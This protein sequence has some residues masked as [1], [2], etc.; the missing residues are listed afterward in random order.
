VKKEIAIRIF[1]LGGTCN[2]QGTSLE[3]DLLSISFNKSFLFDDFWDVIYDWEKFESKLKEN[4]FIP[5]DEVPCVPFEFEIYLWTF[6]EPDTTDYELDY[7]GDGNH[8]DNYAK[9][10]IKS[11][12]SK[13][14]VIGYRDKERFFVCLSDENKDNPT[15]YSVDMECPFDN[16]NYGAG[17]SIEGTLDVFL[18]NLLSLKEYESAINEHIE[19]HM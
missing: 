14:L 8:P 11:D 17:I 19:T 5:A 7:W 15:V 10:V 9:S 6:F 4:D 2:F 16:E 13:L 18:N 1:E 12:I 3:K